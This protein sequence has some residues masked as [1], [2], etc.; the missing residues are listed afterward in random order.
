MSLGYPTHEGG[1][2]AGRVKLADGKTIRLRTHCVDRFWERVAIGCVNFNM[3]RERLTILLSQSELTDLPDWVRSQRLRDKWVPLT[4]EIGVVVS[5][6]RAI[7]CLVK[8][9]Q[10]KR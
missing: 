4:D 7:T 10:K 2:T 1:G 3:A 9:I 8:P 5:G 6:G